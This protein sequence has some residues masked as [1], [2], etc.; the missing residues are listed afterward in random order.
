MNVK[1]GWEGE[2]MDGLLL[3]DIKLWSACTWNVRVIS[4]ENEDR[5]DQGEDMPSSRSRLDKLCELCDG[6]REYSCWSVVVRV[7]LLECGS[8]GTSAGVWI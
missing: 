8:E 5:E 3:M 1:S 7:Q 2:G 4:E 6:Y